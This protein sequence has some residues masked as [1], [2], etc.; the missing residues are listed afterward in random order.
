MLA[1]CGGFVFPIL[2]CFH[3]HS[4]RHCATWRR[5]IV[6]GAKLLSGAWN[7]GESIPRW[8]KE[9]CILP[10]SNQACTNMLILQVWMVLPCAPGRLHT[11]NHVRPWISVNTLISTAVVF[12]QKMHTQT[13][14]ERER[15]IYIYILIFVFRER[16]TMR[17]YIYVCTYYPVFICIYISIYGITVYPACVGWFGSLLEFDPSCFAFLA[18]T[19]G[20]Q[21]LPDAACWGLLCCLLVPSAGPSKRGKSSRHLASGNLQ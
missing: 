8:G 19:P 20:A 7:E 12:V 4:T 3:H 2:E 5:Q 6:A 14:R 15:D 13:E 21:H 10:Q 17:L 1:G 11:F 18:A 16:L 9:S